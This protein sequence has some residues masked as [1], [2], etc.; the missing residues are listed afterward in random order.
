MQAQA[1]AAAQRRQV[2]EEV[3]ASYSE[4]LSTIRKALQT[5]TS[6]REANRIKAVEAT[7]AA[8]RSS[9][10]GHSRSGLKAKDDVK[11]G[12]R[13]EAERDGYGRSQGRASLRGAQDEIF[14]LDVEFEQSSQV[15]EQFQSDLERLDQ[16]KQ[17]E[18][19]T[20]C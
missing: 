11:L 4:E 18:K 20:V 16:V 12:S 13:A 10:D 5:A 7:E 17:A 8:T 9:D 2:V 3:Q 14:N 6:E 15:N 1:D 19:E